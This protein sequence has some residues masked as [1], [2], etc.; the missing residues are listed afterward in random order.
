[1]Y[2]GRA[3]Y[4]DLIRQLV[5]GDHR[6]YALVCSELDDTGW[7]GLGVVV[8]AVFFEA[9]RNCFNGGYSP[10]D[11]IRFVAEFR[12]EI[13]ESGF[14]VDPRPAEM[15]IRAV[16]TGET[17]MVSDL[18]PPVIVETEMLLLWKLLSGLSDPELTLSFEQSD[19]LVTQ[20][21]QQTL[22]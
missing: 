7:E 17:E 14:D 9:V 2:A 5:R 10:A 20:W 4:F 22:G 8:G 1:M 19:A 18:T 12:A 21:S 11:V 16:L 15:L 3:D 6:A 13:A